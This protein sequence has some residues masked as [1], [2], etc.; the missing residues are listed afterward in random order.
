MV[1][2]ASNKW[3]IH[4]DFTNLNKSYL[5]DCYPLPHID[6]LVDAITGYKMLSFI[7]AYSD[8]HQV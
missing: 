4:V 3:R 8:Y 5:K 2:K 6:K 1:K 7:D